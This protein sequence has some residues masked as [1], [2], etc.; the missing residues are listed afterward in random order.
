MA[1]APPQVSLKPCAFKI[2]TWN[3]NGQQG[4]RNNKLYS[5]L[6]LAVDILQV[7]RL[8]LLVIT[9]THSTA[10]GLPIPSQ[11]KTLAT[12]VAPQP[13][14]Q[15]PRASIALV[16]INDG[17]WSCTDFTDL[18]PGYAFLARLHHSRSTES[19]HILAVY[20]DNSGSLTSLAAMY[21]LVSD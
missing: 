3:I 16:A 5:K 15:R 12:S 14:G 21:Q 11:A 8:D 7:E 18:V 1:P 17:S 10:P 13:P 4:R 6:P 20:S 19:F 9:E 2:G